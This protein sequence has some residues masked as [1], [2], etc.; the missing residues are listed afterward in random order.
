MPILVIL[1]L[2]SI[3]ITSFALVS[4]HCCVSSTKYYPFERY[5][6]H[7]IFFPIGIFFINFL[8][9]FQTID[10]FF[11]IHLYTSLSKNSPLHLRLFIGSHELLQEYNERKTQFKTSIQNSSKREIF[12]LTAFKWLNCMRLRHWSGNYIFVDQNVEDAQEY[13]TM[14]HQTLNQQSYSH[15]PLSTKQ[16][17]CFFSSSSHLKSSWIVSK[18]M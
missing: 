11:F 18:S 7:S 4:F 13:S 3:R 17:W 8:A 14:F 12:I 5:N 2:A 6:F 15:E 1:L 16:F 10:S 9:P